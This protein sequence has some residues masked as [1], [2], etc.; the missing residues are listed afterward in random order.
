M[1]ITCPACRLE[2]HDIASHDVIGKWDN[3]RVLRFR[4]KGNDYILAN[5]GR[6]VTK[7][8]FFGGE[9][10]GISHDGVKRVVHKVLDL[11][12]GGAMRNVEDV[13]PTDGEI[14]LQPSAP[15]EI[16][17]DKE[18]NVLVVR[19]PKEQGPMLESHPLEKPSSE[20]KEEKA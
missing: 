10:S 3:V 5:V 20:S 12:H 16:V 4:R 14:H 15:V 6:V 19:P 2:G 18:N 7:T 13:V 1:P 11:G 17:R 9:R 8:G